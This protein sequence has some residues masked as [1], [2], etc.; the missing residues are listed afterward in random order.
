[1]DFKASINQAGRRLQGKLSGELAIGKDNC[2]I[3]IAFSIGTAVGPG[4]EQPHFV[5][6]GQPLRLVGERLN[7]RKYAGCLVIRN[8]SSSLESTT[9]LVRVASNLTDRR[10]NDSV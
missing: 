2:D 6:R 9:R 8:H 5:H 3:D 10:A 7:Y 1:M 4:A